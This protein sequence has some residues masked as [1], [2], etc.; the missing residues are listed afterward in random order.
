MPDQTETQNANEDHWIIRELKELASTLMV[1]VPF[2]LVFTTFFF[3]VRSIP[4][5]SMVPHLQVGDRVVL[6]K[7]NY[8]YNRYSAPYMLHNLLPFKGSLWV[9]EPKRGDVIVFRHPKHARTMIKRLI[10]LPGD[11][12][13]ILDTSLHVNGVKLEARYQ[14]DHNYY[15][16]GQ[17]G[18]RVTAAE[19]RETNEDGKSYLIHK[20]PRRSYLKT[21]E[22][23]V[24]EGHYFFMGDNRDNSI[25]SRSPRGYVDETTIP[26]HDWECGNCK[27]GL[28]TLTKNDTAI[29]FVPHDH[30]I[31]KAQTVLFTLHRCKKGPG[32]DCAQ[33]RMWRAL[34]V[35][36]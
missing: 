34:H 9:Q 24:P 29:G 25:D 33:P 17:G 27:N 12:I 14:G 4:S 21:P 32:L 28:A 30:I 2:W 35:K 19:L 18:G 36:D 15:T 16:H 10:G 26:L 31:G 23:V 13:Q 5:E 6:S 11:R 8:G 22:F 20:W 1:F 7:Y 3:E